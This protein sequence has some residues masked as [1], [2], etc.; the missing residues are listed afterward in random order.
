MNLPGTV[1]CASKVNFVGIFVFQDKGELCLDKG[2]LC[3]G[4]SDFVHKNEFYHDKSDFFQ[5]KLIA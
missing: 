3:L 5:S 1:S 2:E 4:K